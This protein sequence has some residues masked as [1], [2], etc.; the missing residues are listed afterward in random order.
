MARNTSDLIILSVIFAALSSIGMLRAEESPPHKSWPFFVFDNGVG[1]GKLTPAEQAA[2]VKKT[3]Y[4]GISYNYTNDSDLTERMKAFKEAGLPI[5]A[6]Y[7]SLYLDKPQQYD[8]N[9]KESIR[10][11]RGSD[12]LL[13]LMVREGK[14]GEEDEKAVKLLREIAD[15]AEEAG[16]RV[17]IYPHLGNYTETTADALRIVKL[18]DRKNLG[19]TMNLC[20][21]LLT[22]NGAKIPEIIRT[23]APHLFLVSINGADKS[24]IRKRAILPLGEGDYDV[25]AVLKTLKEVKY[26]GPIGLQSYK[27]PGDEV[28]HLKQSM[29]TWKKYLA[30]LEEK[31]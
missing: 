11:L 23:A 16:L 17:A 24:G 7:V 30:A 28:E 27:I 15:M 9:L 18:A 3:G 10:L 26:A 5:Y 25:L 6:I 12:T 13:W 8:P 4:D 2:L 20:H 31:K 21:E 29:T 14:R 22:G 1:R 19:V